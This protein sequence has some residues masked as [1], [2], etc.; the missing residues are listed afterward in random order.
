MSSLESQEHGND[1]E[2]PSGAAAAIVAAATGSA[3]LGVLTLGAEAFAPL[4]KLLSFVASVGSLSGISSMAAIT[5]LVTWSILDR[6]WKGKPQRANRI[7]CIT[8]TLLG[9]GFTLT[10]PPV[11][12]LF[13]G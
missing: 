7:L 12:R 6:C 9:I 2:L 13:G 5:W 1:D 8:G 10:F 3:T 4:S 11:F